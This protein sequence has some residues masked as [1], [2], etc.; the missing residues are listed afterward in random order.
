VQG[1]FARIDSGIN[2]TS[3][4][5]STVH[6]ATIFRIDLCRFMKFFCACLCFK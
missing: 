2:R 6:A 4:H 5:F 1:A 3:F